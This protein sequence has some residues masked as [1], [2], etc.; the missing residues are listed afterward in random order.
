M[1]AAT[2]T[3]PGSSGVLV[4]DE[5]PTPSPGPGEVLV[6]VMVAGV[7]PTDWKSRAG[8]EVPFAFQVP[9]QD[10]AGVIEA[11]G[12]G[13]DAARVGSRVWVYFAAWKRQWGTA[14]QFCVVPSVQAVEL[15]SSAS[16]ELGASLG[17]P[18]L[19]AY[20]CL[21]ADG[22]ISGL[23]V[24]VAGGAGAVGHAAI[25]LAVWSG[26]RVI[27]T[28]SGPEKGVLADVAGASVVVNYRDDDAASLIRDAAPDGVSRIVEL[29]LGP[30]LSLDLA[31]AAPFAVISTYAADVGEA[32]VPVRALM[33]PNLVL[34]FVLVY[35]IP[36]PALREAVD[37]VCE[38]LA[39]GAL[40][41]LPVHRFA[42]ADA[43]A[44]HDAV[45][46]GAVGKVVIEMP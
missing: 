24:L 43:A 4:V 34:R 10:A 27:S 32:T 5:V 33:T 17:I 19:T 42:L 37:G 3:A 22:P 6:R 8:A 1:L 2:Y 23:D 38:A 41:P 7:N 20:H 16:F 13:V 46:E 21:L 28:V 12:S 36:R 30:N 14:A 25:E 44:A 18:A 40:T 35:T 29:A 45:Q 11:V 15:P 26:A 39:V 9:G 31:V